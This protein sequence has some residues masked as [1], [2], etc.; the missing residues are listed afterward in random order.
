MELYLLPR[1]CIQG[2]YRDDCTVAVL[3][4]LIAATV[5][6]ADVPS[7]RCA[8][9]LCGLILSYLYYYLFKITGNWLSRNPIF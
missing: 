9:I 8:S 5:F 7:V 3:F 2:V 6:D 4:M 1:I